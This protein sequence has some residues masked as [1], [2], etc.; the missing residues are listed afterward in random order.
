[1]A[2]N[3][4]ANVA[5]LEILPPQHVVAGLGA[6][7]GLANLAGTIAAWWVLSRRIGGLHG[8]VISSV[9]IR[10]HL[11]AIPS[12]LFAVAATLM[13]AVVLPTGRLNAIVTVTLA[14][15]GALLLY[16]LFAKASG[17]TELTDLTTTVRSRLRR[18]S[19]R[20]LAP[21][22]RAGPWPGRSRA[23]GCFPRCGSIP[24]AGGRQGATGA[25]AASVFR[26]ACRARRAARP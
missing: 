12:V 15:C 14:G 11:S 24:L 25:L 19:G 23:T 13:V 4:A 9:L 10:M 5:A 17:I 20:T 18:R 22:R 1:M 16:V 3:I 6:G 8:S 26:P 7:F 21:A 2:V